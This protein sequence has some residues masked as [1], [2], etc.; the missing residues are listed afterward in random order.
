MR[1]ETLKQWV[2][3]TCGELIKKPEEGWLEWQVERRSDGGYWTFDYRICHH[4]LSSP[5]DR[6][7][8][9]CYQN[10]GGHNHL[11]DFLGPD[12]LTRLIEKVGRGEVKDPKSWAEAVRRL[13]TPGYEEARQYFAEAFEDGELD[14]IEEGERA[15]LNAL[16]RIIRIYGSKERE[17]S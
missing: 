5:R 14:Q 3:D 4:L 12:G 6:E 13:F 2:C 1:L 15:T 10:D 11:D 7:N 16:R 9:G 8:N 17:S